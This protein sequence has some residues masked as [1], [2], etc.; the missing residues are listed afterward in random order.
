MTDIIDSLRSIEK[1]ADFITSVEN[2]VSEIT[3]K[4]QDELMNIASEIMSEY[5]VYGRINIIVNEDITVGFIGVDTYSNVL[6]IYMLAIEKGTKLY[7]PEHIPAYVFLERTNATECTINYIIKA[8]KLGYVS[9]LPDELVETIYREHQTILERTLVEKVML[10]EK[11]PLKLPITIDS[12]L[13][14]KLRINKRTKT[15]RHIII[16]AGAT[17][18]D[19]GENLVEITVYR[20]REPSVFIS[21][22]IITYEEEP[23]KKVYSS[24]INIIP[25][26]A[27]KIVKQIIM[28]SEYVYK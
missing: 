9:G 23:Y 15:L 11:E 17:Y 12:E 22:P 16:A 14:E 10:T 28:Y 6:V 1:V 18:R 25:E 13:K 7:I 2:E 21:A 8:A 24:T 20:D 26:M 4:V 27:E 5:P 3:V 19:I